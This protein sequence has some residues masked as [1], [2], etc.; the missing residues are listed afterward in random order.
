VP[1]LCGFTLGAN[2]ELAAI[3]TPSTTFVLRATSL[4]SAA[5]AKTMNRYRTEL[6][7]W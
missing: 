6:P 7:P 1:L 3:A 5:R 2:L 4:T